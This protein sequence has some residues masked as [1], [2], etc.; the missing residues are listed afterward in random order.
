[1]ISIDNEEK[2]SKKRY[3]YK[4]YL[5]NEFRGVSGKYQKTRAYRASPKIAQSSHQSHITG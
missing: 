2:E 5:L 4:A 3:I 1:M